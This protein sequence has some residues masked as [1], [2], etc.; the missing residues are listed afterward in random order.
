MEWDDSEAT[1]EYAWLKLMVDYKFDR[2]QGYG[3]G[4]HFYVR[5]ISWLAQFKDVAARRT[6]YRY[7]RK[8]LVFIGQPE[9]YQL[10]KLAMPEMEKD[11]RRIVANRHGIA[12]Y[13]TWAN[14]KAQKDLRLMSLRTLY[15]GL[16]DG[17]RIDVFRRYNEGLLTN[18]QVIASSEI[19]DD[20]W[21]S[22]GN[23]LAARLEQ[24]GFP[25]A[26][27]KFERVCL[28]D[29]FTGSGT[30]L[31][32]Y[33]DAKTTWDGKIFKFCSQAENHGKMRPE[34]AD[35][36]HIQVHHYLASTKAR[37]AVEDALPKLQE[38]MPRFSCKAS[39][40]WVFS[41]EPDVV[42]GPASDAELLAWINGHYDPSIQTSHNCV[43]GKSIALGY[44]QCGLPI[45]LEHNTPNNSIALIWAES[46]PDS[47]SPHIMRPLFPRTDRHI[48]NGQS[49]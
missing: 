21:Q 30:T 12:Y 35:Q 34:L 25:D 11:A 29:D 16:S 10:I 27:Q 42:M 46:R 44:K 5:L 15:V 8:H 26:E 32:R 7:L 33:D 28:V 45:V 37:D 43:D 39:Y 9:L 24:S 6:A 38:T 23:K 49:V 20:K 31:I 13:E 48:D 47:K 36:C 18:E 3:P 41:A 17:A 2:Y 22:L 1:T 19:S 40:S 14:K 4:I